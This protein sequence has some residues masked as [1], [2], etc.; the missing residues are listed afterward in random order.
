MD[1]VPSFPDLRFAC[2]RKSDQYCKPCNAWKSPAVCRYRL[3]SCP[4]NASVQHP[5]TSLSVMGSSLDRHVETVNITRIL[6]SAYAPAFTSTR[7]QILLTCTHHT[8]QARSASTF[9]H[10]VA[11][12]LFQDT[13][14]HNSNVYCFPPALVTIFHVSQSLPRGAEDGCQRKLLTGC[15]VKVRLLIF[16]LD[17]WQLV[18]HE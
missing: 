13:H 1:V 4:L 3:V 9:S 18:S 17:R 8:S 6:L 5:S 7:L 11:L 16:R 15:L 14:E 10:E 2:C 12:H